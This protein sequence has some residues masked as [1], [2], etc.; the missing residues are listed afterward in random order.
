MSTFFFFALGFF[1]MN[2]TN[3]VSYAVAIYDY[4]ATATNQLSLRVGERVAILSK[5]GG[6][7]GW[8]K[9][10]I[11]QYGKVSPNLVS[12]VQHFF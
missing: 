3:V 9:G 2:P 4:S 8:W 12:F 1:S 5:A 6:D 7:K 11:V 10:K